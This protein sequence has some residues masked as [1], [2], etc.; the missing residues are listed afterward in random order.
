METPIPNSGAELR[1]VKYDE[2]VHTCPKCRKPF[3]RIVYED[4]SVEQR[5]HCTCGEPLPPRE[6]KEEKQLRAMLAE[7]FLLGFFCTREGFNGEC[8]VGELSD[9]LKPYDENEWCRDVMRTTPEIGECL[10]E[11]LRR[12]LK[13]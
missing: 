2:E 6:A 11:A 1:E 5:S 10:D 4:G 9:G 12:I 8:A 3:K 7:A 13:K